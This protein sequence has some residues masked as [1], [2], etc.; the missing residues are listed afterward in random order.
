MRKIRFVSFLL[1]LWV[2]S[3]CTDILDK[4]PYGLSNFWQ[5]PADAE[6][7]INAAYE[8]LLFEE[9]YGRGQFWMSAASDDFI[10][11]RDKPTEK[12]LTSFSTNENTSSYAYSYWKHMYQIIRRANDVLE[13]VPQIGM[14]AELKDRILGEANFLMG[15]GYFQLVRRYGGVP[16]Y[17]Y[18]KPDEINKPR[19]TTEESYRRIEEYLQTAA[20]LLPWTHSAEAVGRAHK[21]AALGLLAK[22]YAYQQKWQESKDASGQVINSGKYTLT[23]RYQDIFTIEHEKASENL[24][25]VQCNPVRHESTITSIVQLPGTITNGSGWKYFAPTFSLAKAFEPGDE[26]RAATLVDID[27]GVFRF[28]GEDITLSE[29]LV[30]AWGTAHIAVKYVHPY[31]EKYVGWESGLDI[32]VLR[33]SDVLLLNAEAIIMLNGGGPNAPDLGVAA[34]ATAFNQVRVRAFA[35]DGSKAITA[36]SFTDL[37][38]ERRCEFAFEEQRHYDLVRWG[39]AE[40]VYNAGIDDPRGSRPFDASVHSLFPLPQREIDNSNGMLKQNPGY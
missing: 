3:S 1:S 11:N 30:G 12:L 5:T 39:L 17:D 10:V 33:Y 24:F 6:L 36:P 19:E 35:G 4:E 2:L 38:H 40:E 16:F 18:Q 22:V 25:A 32:P 27:G 7:G 14:D 23:E 8:P 20:E 31:Q 34:A 29:N 37:V 13:N 28:D 15:F 26:R 9:V 21:G